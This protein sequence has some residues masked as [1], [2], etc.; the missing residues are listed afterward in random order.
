MKRIFL[1]LVLL[2]ACRLPLPAQGLADGIR[3]YEAGRFHD[4]LADFQRQAAAASTAEAHAWVG[5]A[6][7]K[8][9]RWSDAVQQFEAAVRL[10]PA[11][12][13]NQLWLA[14]AC[15]RKAEFGSVFTAFG[16]ARKALRAFEAAVSLMPENLGARFDLMQYYAEAPG[17][18]GGGDDK[19]AKQAKEIARL[20]PRMGFVARAA[21][22]ETDKRWE[23][24]RRELE[25]AAAAFPL[26]ASAHAD[27]AA[28]LLQRSDFEGAAKSAR[29]ALTLQRT[30]TAVLLLAAASIRLGR[31]LGEGEKALRELARGPLREDD[32]SFE[33][34]WCW[35]GECCLAAGKKE[36]AREALR[37]SLAFNPDYGPARALQSKL[38]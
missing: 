14:R 23:D 11:D 28:H 12:G 37:A 10:T 1:A 9:R 31:N 24:A 20:S 35:I 32:P 8:L 16:T 2:C 15:G 27:L 25:Q 29:A 38:R 36:E 13:M 30:P 22:Y 26:D 4:A 7:L 17:I 34:V 21:I 18:A 5:R 6:L 33:E 3:L 19:A